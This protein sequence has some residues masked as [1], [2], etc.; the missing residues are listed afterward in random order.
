LHDRCAFE[1]CPAG[2]PF[3]YLA[4]SFRNRGDAYNR[5][6][7]SVVV[8]LEA[9]GNRVQPAC[10]C[11]CAADYDD[12]TVGVPIGAAMRDWTHS[13][14]V[15]KVR[16]CTHAHTPPSHTH[17]HTRTHTRMPKPPS[18][19]LHEGNPSNTVLPPAVAIH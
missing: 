2:H 14:A 6:V 1:G 8:D 4:T 7:R 17:T 12:I 9:E 19:F 13:K 16:G 11:M 15:V 18:C 10:V 3:L 5:F